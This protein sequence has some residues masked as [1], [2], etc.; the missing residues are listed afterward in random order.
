MELFGTDGIRDIANSGNMKPEVVL[1]VAR[2]Y[3]FLLKESKEK[4]IVVV[5]K[6]TRLSGYALI[7]A[8][9]AGFL[10]SGC[11]VIDVGILSTPGISFLVRELKADGGAVVSAS[12][13]PYE[14]NGVKF[15]NSFGE[16]LSPESEL[17][18][19]RMLEK[20]WG[21]PTGIYLGKLYKVDPKEY[22]VPF[23]LKV[24]KGLKLDGLKV[25]VDAANGALFEIAPLVFENLGAEVIKVGCEPDGININAGVGSTSTGEMVSA[26]AREEA[27]LGF[28]FDGDGDRVMLSDSRGMIADGDVILYLAAS[29]LKPSAVVGTVMSNLGLEEVLSSMKIGFIRVPVGDRWVYEEVKKRDLPLGGE[30]SGHVIFRPEVCT[31]DGMVTAIKILTFGESLEHY[32]DSFPRYPQRI[33]NIRV[34]DK[35][36]IIS[37]ALLQ[38][39]LNRISE[40]WKK[41]LRVVLRPSGTEPLI[42]I[43]VEGKDPLLVDSIGLRLAQLIISLDEE[44]R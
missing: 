26:V 3:G 8:L 12:H 1:K 9:I 29:K 27:Y 42:R 22:Y 28:A 11:D 36:S 15:F 34:K 32:I 43:M 16:K 40:S 37:S 5:G 2:A 20:D 21:L 4:P 13:N 44:G 14:Y 25:V 23:L 31:G 18:I 10:S 30:P 17:M 41:S 38:E 33:W 24:A 6:D 39:E 7:S 19:E 35:N